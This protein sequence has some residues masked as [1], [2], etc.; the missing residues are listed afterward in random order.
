[1]TNCEQTIGMPLIQ[2]K[3]LN[4]INNDTRAV[5]ITEEPRVHIKLQNEMKTAVNNR[6]MEY[7]VKDLNDTIHTRMTYA[8]CK[9]HI[10]NKASHYTDSVL[11]Q[12]STY[13]LECISQCYNITMCILRTEHITHDIMKTIDLYVRIYVRFSFICPHSDTYS[14]IITQQIVLMCIIQFCRNINNIIKQ[15][16]RVKYQP[17]ISN[18]LIQAI[19]G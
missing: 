6:I 2:F 13:F 14:N 11:D 18:T 19:K 9:L 16:V 5:I 12:Y 17:E 10:F 8:L 3:N 15:K 1:M 7:L 4:N